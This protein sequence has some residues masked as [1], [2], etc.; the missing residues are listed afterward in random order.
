MALAASFTLVAVNAAVL[1][2]R[3]SEGSANQQAAVRATL[4]MMVAAD[5]VGPHARRRCPL[6]FGFLA[7]PLSDYLGL[8]R[9]YGSPVAGATLADLGDE[10]SRV[11]ADRWMIDSL[12]IH[13]AEG[14]VA[15]CPTG[16]A[17]SGAGAGRR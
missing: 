3:L 11:D 9:H 8:V 5:A 14:S 17:G 10:R 1:T 6:H 16:G 12:G 7:V 15:G 13:L 4:T 2:P